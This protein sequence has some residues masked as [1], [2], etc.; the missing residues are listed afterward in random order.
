MKKIYKKLHN[1]YIHLLRT[2]K[3]IHKKP[4]VI[5]CEAIAA[6]YFLYIISI[7]SN[8]SPILNGIC[9]AVGAIGASIIAIVNNKNE[10][11]LSIL[12]N[13]IERKR[14]LI[15]SIS[16][17]L[18]MRMYNLER[19]FW[20][21]DSIDKSKMYIN[22]TAV[23]IELKNYRESV[24]IHNK[25]VRWHTSELYSIFGKEEAH[26]FF[27]SDKDCI[28]NRIPCIYTSINDAH[29]SVMQLKKTIEADCEPD[30]EIVKK[31]IIETKKKIQE[32]YEKIDEFIYMIIEKIYTNNKELIEH[33][34]K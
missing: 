14:I 4:L 28:G 25:Y 16:E 24:K 33:Y 17:T 19:V 27:V 9:I 12:N 6:L 2:L 8:N 1:I 5:V 3:N 10:K 18:S 32:A 31:L 11:E 21:M 20:E 15:K 13:I 23:D 30:E 29:N 26:S 7:N 34:R 22:N